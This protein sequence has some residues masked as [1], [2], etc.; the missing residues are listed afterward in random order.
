M[1]DI[2]YSKKEI[3]PQ[4]LRECPFCKIQHKVKHRNQ[5]FC[6]RKCAYTYHNLL[7]QNFKKA[8]AVI[9]EKGYIT[10][11]KN[12]NLSEIPQGKNQTQNTLKDEMENNMK[13]LNGLKINYLIGSIFDLNDFI[14]AKFN[15]SA[16][17]SKTRIPNT[18]ENE[19]CYYL[20]F[21]NYSIYFIN[22]NQFLVTKN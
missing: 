22:E 11:N 6:S 12:D 1:S 10:E 7:A 18:T 2:N 14:N 5:E 15:F 3:E 20:T 4:Y 13:F 19:Q 17:T 16:F 9:A 21:N 8:E